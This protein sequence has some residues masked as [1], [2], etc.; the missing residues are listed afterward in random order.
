MNKGLL[1]SVLL[2]MCCSSVSLAQTE[3][4]F[5]SLDFYTVMSRLFETDR[6]DSNKEALWK[7]NYSERIM[8]Q[9]SD[10][11]YCHTT[12]DT[13]M[14]F[15]SMNDKYAT[16][17]FSTYDYIGGSRT[18]CHACSPTLGVA[19]FIKSKGENWKIAQ[20]E[21]NLVQ[22]GSW[23]KKDG[24][25][26]IVK[27]GKEFYCLRVKSGI[28]GNQGYVSGSSSYYLL[29]EYSHFSRVFFYIYMD[30]S[31]GAKGRKLGET[32]EKSI[33]L[34]PSND[35]YYTIEMTTKSSHLKLSEKSIFKYFPESQTYN[36][37]K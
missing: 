10:D 9:V 26:S 21:K 17:L 3:R 29:D 6:F 27:M 12:V 2:V 30:S 31:V 15:S 8:M 20:F 32:T 36:L 11:G 14:Y 28:D 25:F 4:S 1:V 33:R 13:I 16:I 19:I 22:Y 34:L 35:D 18:S 5:S 23:G 7:P 24:S 37:V